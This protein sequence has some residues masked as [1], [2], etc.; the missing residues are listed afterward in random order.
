[1][2]TELNKALTNLYKEAGET[3]TY[4]F[5]KTDNDYNQKSITAFEEFRQSIFCV[6]KDDLYS[7]KTQ[8][9]EIVSEIGDILG[10]YLE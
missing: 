6:E 1:M 4:F 7:L 9:R 2:V 5:H 10:E 3:K 8:Y